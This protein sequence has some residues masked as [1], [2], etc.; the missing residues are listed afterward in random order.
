MDIKELIDLLDFL[1]RHIGDEYRATEEDTEPSMQVTVACDDFM[2][3]WVYQ[4]GDN[5]YTGACY[6]YP[7]WAVISL[8][9]DSSSEYY[10]KDIVNQ[11][12]E[13]IPSVCDVI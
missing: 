12:E 4:T 13:L 6:S 7:H 8:Y 3:K 10:A 11:L 9:R 5:S 2:D 1:K